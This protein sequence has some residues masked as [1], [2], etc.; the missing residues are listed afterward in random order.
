MT[1]AAILLSMTTLAVPQ[2]DSADGG[3][4]GGDRPAGAAF[5]TD[6]T[7]VRSLFEAPINWQDSDAITSRTTR[8]VPRLP[9]LPGKP[10]LSPSV[11]MTL[12]ALPTTDQPSDAASAPSSSGRSTS[13]VSPSWTIVA[14]PAA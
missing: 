14:A 13:Y 1:L 11:T 9:S 12:A 5:A 4:R 6:G 7:A 8:M 10:L 3:H 2:G